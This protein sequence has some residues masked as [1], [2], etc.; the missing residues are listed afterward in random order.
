MALPLGRC[1]ACPDRGGAVVQISHTSELRLLASC[2]CWKGWPIGS[3]G[4]PERWKRYGFR[5]PDRRVI[6]QDNRNQGDYTLGGA[7]TNRGVLPGQR[8]RTGA[9][10]N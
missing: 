3:L 2:M 4:G 6:W 8:H 5:R 7:D 1:P 10:R 9:G